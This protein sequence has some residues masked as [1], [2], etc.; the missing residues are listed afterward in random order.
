MTMVM[1]VVGGGPDD[2]TESKSLGLYYGYTTSHTH[3]NT[4]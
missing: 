3:S 2:E 1:M 4:G